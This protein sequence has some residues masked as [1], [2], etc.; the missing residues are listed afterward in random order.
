MGPRF[1]AA[2]AAVTYNLRCCAGLVCGAGVWQV[3]VCV[4]CGCVCVVASFVCFVVFA[5][6]ASSAPHFSLSGLVYRSCG[7]RGPFIPLDG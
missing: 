2:A 7:L 5:V 1:L 3:G 4:V 6:S